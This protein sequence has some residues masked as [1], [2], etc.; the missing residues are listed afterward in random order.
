[1]LQECVFDRPQKF[2]GQARLV[3]PQHT[4]SCDEVVFSLKKRKCLC[5]QHP[6]GL[7]QLSASQAKKL[8]LELAVV[9][10]SIR[11][12]MCEHVAVLVVG[13]ELLGEELL[14]RVNEGEEHFVRA[15]AAQLCDGSDPLIAD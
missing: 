9:L 5:E 2:V 13:R 10:R 12:Q 1:M 6:L 14:I 4:K 3:I 8:R 7:R 11:E 15:L